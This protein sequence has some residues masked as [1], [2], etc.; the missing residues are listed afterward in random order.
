[1]QKSEIKRGQWTAAS[2][3]FQ[4]AS[5]LMKPYKQGISGTFWERSRSIRDAFLFEI[6]GLEIKRNQRNQT[7][8]VQKTAPSL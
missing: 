2:G 6:S 5:R 3:Q 4:K 8:N 1:V 7:R